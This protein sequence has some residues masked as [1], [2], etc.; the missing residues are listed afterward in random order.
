MIHDSSKYKTLSQ[1]NL[2]MNAVIQEVWKSHH[3]R[4]TGSSFQTL[5]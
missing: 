5:I 4:M 1:G 3:S 2:L